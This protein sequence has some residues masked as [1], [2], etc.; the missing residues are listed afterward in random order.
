MTFHDYLTLF[1]R[2]ALAAAFLVVT[3]AGAAF[4]FPQKFLT[5]DS[6]EVKADALVVLGGDASRAERAAELYHQGVAPAIVVTGYGDCLANTELLERRG[7]PSTA[8]LPAPAALT[9][10]ENATKSVPLLR[11]LRAHR[12]IIVTSWYHSRRAMACF[13]H[14]APDLQ[15][16]S[17]PTYAN[18][19]PKPPN[20]LGFNWHVNYEYVK[21]V[22]YMFSHGVFPL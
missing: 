12:V 22:I 20:R 18:F 6:G 13:E 5:V 19:Q 14:V 1:W 7:V 21:L 8:S 4:L 16:F 10:F 3:L 15:F 2:I 11:A 17:R 9:T